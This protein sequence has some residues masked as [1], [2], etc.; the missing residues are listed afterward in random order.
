MSYYSF[1]DVAQRNQ[2]CVI[3]EKQHQTA[4]PKERRGIRDVRGFH[5]AR[6]IHQRLAEIRHPSCSIFR[7]D[8][9]DLRIEKHT[10]DAAQGASPHVC[11]LET[12]EI[13]HANLK[14]HRPEPCP[15]LNCDESH[16]MPGM[17]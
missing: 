14:T 17:S 5:P 13:T 9:W 6:G 16:S 1:S 11:H 12:T 7:G 15:S 3:E 8:S 2:S 10:C 4:R